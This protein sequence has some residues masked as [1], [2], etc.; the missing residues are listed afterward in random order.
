[1]LKPPYTKTEFCFELFLFLN[2]DDYYSVKKRD[3]LP[4]KKIKYR[5]LQKHSFAN[6]KRGRYD[7]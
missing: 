7:K 1:M 2:C 3:K 5:A 6:M 4:L